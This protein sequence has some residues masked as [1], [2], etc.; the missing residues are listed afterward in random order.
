MSLMP[1]LAS[2]SWNCL[3]TMMLSIRVA[4]L[5]VILVGLVIVGSRFL[6]KFIYMN[7]LV[8]GVF[9]MFNEI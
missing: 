3:P 1:I 7:S 6:S 4:L 2:Y 5:L 9:V 8:G